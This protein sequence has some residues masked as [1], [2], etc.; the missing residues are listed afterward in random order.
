[1]VGASMTGTEMIAAAS[2]VCGNHDVDETGGTEFTTR[3]AVMAIWSQCMFAQWM[4]LHWKTRDPSNACITD[5]HMSLDHVRM[6]LMYAVENPSHR[7]RTLVD[8]KAMVEK[9]VPIIR[10]L[11]TA[12]DKAEVDR[13][14]FDSEE[15]LLP[16]TAAPVKQLREFYALLVETLKADASIPFFVWRAFATWGE[17]ILAGLPDGKVKEL[18]LDL[19]KRVADLVEEDIKPDLNEALVGALKWRGSEDLE[20]MATA[21]HG[22][23]K[24]RMRGRESCLFLEVDKPTGGTL[25]VML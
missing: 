5:K 11:A 24:P 25:T 12:H 20:A 2:H 10:G 1:M 9:W 6:F 21:V 8:I 13:C 16:L 14:E 15:L 19:A 18:R 4:V 23:A 17:V 7:R 3:S 22:G